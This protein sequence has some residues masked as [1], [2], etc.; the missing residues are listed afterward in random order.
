MSLGNLERQV[1]GLDAAV[2]G[3]LAPCH[4]DS[5]CLL[6]IDHPPVHF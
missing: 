4:I 6:A 2:K 5:F 3:A 1:A